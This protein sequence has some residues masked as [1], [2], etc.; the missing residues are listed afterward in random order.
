MPT[1]TDTLRARIEAFTDELIE[2]IQASVAEQ[3]TS[4]VG[5]VVSGGRAPGRGRGRPRGSATPSTGR[6]GKGQK[7]SPKLLA[8]TTERLAAYIAKNPGQR[9]EQIS[10]GLGTPTKDLALP[11]KKLVGEK[12]IKTRGQRRATRYYP[13][14]G[15]RGPERGAKRAKKRGAKKGSRRVAKRGRKASKKA[16]KRRTKARAP[17]AKA[18]AA[19][20]VA[21]E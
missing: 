14:G 12:R 16:G 4:A 21:A 20:S 1:P 8:A 7:R 3:L 11:V 13:G 2:I 17:V 18:E 9:I 5:A 6:R 15:S 19:G 10:E